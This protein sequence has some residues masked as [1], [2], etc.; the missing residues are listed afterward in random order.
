FEELEKTRKEI[1]EFIK[2]NKNNQ[3]Y[4]TLIS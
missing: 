2:A 1:D 3:N 4:S